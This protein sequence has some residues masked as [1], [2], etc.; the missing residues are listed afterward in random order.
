MTYPRWAIES[1]DKAEEDFTAWL[2]EAG[3]EVYHELL[4]KTGDS[5][6]ARAQAEAVIEHWI[7]SRTKEIGSTAERAFVFQLYLADKLGWYHYLPGELDTIEE[8]LATLVDELEEGTPR[9][10][11][12]KFIVETIMPL[13][14]KAG[15]KPEDVWGIPNAISKA[16]AAVP[17][18]RDIMRRTSDGCEV[19]KDDMDEILGI[20]RQISNPEINNRAFREEMGKLRGREPRETLAPLTVTKY[21]M[22][23]GEQWYLVKSP[24]ALHSRAI[25]MGLKGVAPDV[26]VRDPWGLVKLVASLLP[27]SSAQERHKDKNL[28]TLLNLIESSD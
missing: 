3:R 11:D 27:R 17:V 25:E 26:E 10:Y 18:L 5:K 20:A 15:A 19:P 1:Y 9:Y 4:D 24:S 21:H 8:L 14:R 6:T 2:R 13:L 22:P 12:L 28:E 16:R 23:G 7:M